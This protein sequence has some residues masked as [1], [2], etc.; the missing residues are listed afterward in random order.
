MEHRAHTARG[1]AP[2]PGQVQVHRGR[3]RVLARA[4][5]AE[6]PEGVRG[7]HALSARHPTRHPYQHAQHGHRA[8]RSGKLRRSAK[9][10]LNI[11]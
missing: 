1:G 7:R 3:V 11:P 5:R 6:T 2:P 4:L 8:P 9:N 10:K